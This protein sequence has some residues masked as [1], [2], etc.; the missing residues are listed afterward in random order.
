MRISQTVPMC[1]E[2]AGMLARREQQGNVF[3]FCNDCMNIYQ[4]SGTGT[5]ECEIEI[6]DKGEDI[7]T[8]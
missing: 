2:C 1:P 5:A 7:C 3:Y 4:L 6:S 8:E